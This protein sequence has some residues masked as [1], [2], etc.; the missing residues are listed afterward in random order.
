MMCKHCKYQAR[1]GTTIFL[2]YAKRAFFAMGR[3]ENA[4][5]EEF[6]ERSYHGV[7]GVQP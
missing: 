5:C 6:Q 2:A 4:D 3:D 7:I 1:C